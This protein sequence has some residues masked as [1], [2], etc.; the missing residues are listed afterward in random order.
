LATAQARYQEAKRAYNTN[1]AN[2]AKKWRDDHTKALVEARALESGRTIEL[3]KELLYGKEKARR[4]GAVSKQIRQKPMK[5]PVHRIECTGQDGTIF[6][7]LTQDAIVQACAVSNYKGQT[8]SALTPFLCKPL[9]SQIGYLT[10]K[11]ASNQILAGTFN[12]PPNVDQY[13]RDFILALEMPA[14]IRQ[15]PQLDMSVTL[16]DHIWAG[17]VNRNGLLA[18]LMDSLF[19]ITNQS[20]RTNILPTWM[21]GCGHYPLRSV[22]SQT[23]GSRSLIWKF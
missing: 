10:E 20:Y 9:V 5:E 14:S 2:A 17:D 12:V 15:A 6:E 1:K 22:L 16:N 3:E 19:L 13:T 8:Q 11:E 7:C 23:S 21:S 18:N 4:L